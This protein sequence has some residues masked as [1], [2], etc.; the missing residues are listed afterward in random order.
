MEW[1]AEGTSWIPVLWLQTSFYMSIISETDWLHKCTHALVSHVRC[2]W[3]RSVCSHCSSGKSGASSAGPACV[4][5]TSGA[6][7]LKAAHKKVKPIDV[8]PHTKVVV[9]FLCCC[10]GK[11]SKPD[12]HCQLVIVYVWLF[13]FYIDAILH[14]KW[15]VHVQQRL[16]IHNLFTANFDPLNPELLAQTWPNARAPGWNIAWCLSSW[17]KHGLIPELLA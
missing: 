17:L 5:A 15:M 12:L 8:V 1:D 3:R 2:S 6:T 10:D 7:A 16:I 13:I 9:C 4:D 14:Q 11:C